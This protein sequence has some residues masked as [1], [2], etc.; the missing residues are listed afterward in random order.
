MH[1]DKRR[2]KLIFMSETPRFIVEK[3]YAPLQGQERLVSPA[4]KK[5]LAVLGAASSRALLFHMTSLT[6]LQEKELLANFRELEKALWSVFGYGADIMLKR[7]SEEL[8]AATRFCDMGF[9][10]MLDELRRDGLLAFMRSVDYGE[11]VLL[12]YRTTAF[13]DRM[14]AGFFDLPAEESRVAVMAE[15]AVPASVAATTYEQL[16]G[17]YGE[18]SVAEKAG[19]WA[20]SLRRSAHLRLATDNTWL[21]EKGIEVASHRQDR[22]PW[23]SAAVLCAYDIERIGGNMPRALESHDF[24]VLE[25]SSAV[26]AKAAPSP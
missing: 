22:L 4:A 17:R 11:H 8:A 1:G 15:A 23:T 25:D 3:G 19:E 16:A 5:A 20:F 26:Y 24:V 14:A 7:L 9:N 18:K 2:G 13:R 12:F 21:A 6:G 10:E